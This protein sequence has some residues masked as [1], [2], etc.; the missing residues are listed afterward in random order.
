MEIY[1]SI[2]TF[3]VCLFGANAFKWIAIPRNL[4]QDEIQRFGARQF[5]IQIRKEH[6]KALGQKYHS[7]EIR[8]ATALLF[9][10]KQLN[11]YKFDYG[12]GKP[13]LAQTIINRYVTIAPY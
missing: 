13:Y 5:L 1:P 11:F 2:D 4:S 8:F 3:R 12:A 10:H 7:P 6:S 9:P